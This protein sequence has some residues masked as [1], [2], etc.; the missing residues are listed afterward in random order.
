MKTLYVDV[1]FLI[2]FTVDLLALYFASSFAKIPTTAI[3]LSIAAAIGALY[4]VICTLFIENYFVAVLFAIA[5]LVL[6]VYIGS[7]KISFIRRVKYL[8][9]FL[10]FEILIGGL[11]Y[12]A[13]TL[14][15]RLTQNVS[16][17]EGAAVNKKL[18]LLSALVLLSFGILKLIVALFG[19]SRSIKSVPLYFKIGDIEIETEALVDSGNLAEDPFEK[20]PVMFIKKSEMVKHTKININPL[21]SEESKFKNKIRI[22]PIKRAGDTKI[23][24]GF[25]PDFVS[26]IKNK[27]REEIKVV[28]AIDDEGGNYGGFSALLPISAI[29]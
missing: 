1:Y 19:N 22:I 7:R 13:Y 20:T 8:I 6:I 2:N 29:E 23:F 10:I 9:A 14:L 15:D 16:F 18:L 11:V 27:K 17:T 3:R 21:L 4:A 25:K 12:Y 24:Y 5:T 26:V 28:I